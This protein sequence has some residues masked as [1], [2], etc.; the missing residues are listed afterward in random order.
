MQDYY[1]L[2]Q[3]HPKADQDSIHAAYLRLRE[4]YAAERMEGAAE[5]L[6]ALARKRRDEIERAY[7]TLNDPVRRAA[8]DAES[9][10][11]AGAKDQP[12][13]A[14]DVAEALDYRPLP[15]AKRKS[16]PANFNPQP[17]LSAA[18]AAPRSGRKSR[19]GRPKWV[20]PGTLGGSIAAIIMIVTLVVTNVSNI[21][22]AAPS[23]SGTAPTVQ[24]TPS[25]AEIINQFEGEIVA[26]R[27]V[28]QQIPNNANAWI[29][30]GNA[31]YDSVQIVH[32]RLPDSAIYTERLPRWIEASDAYSKALALS[33]NNPTVRADLA[34]SYCYYGTST[35]EA[36]FVDRGIT[37][38]R[39][40]IV[41]GPQDPRAMLNL[42]ICLIADDPPQTAEAVSTWKQLVGMTTLDTGMRNA[43]QRLL[44]TYGK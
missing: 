9:R 22:K 37:E 44:D 14:T 38:A 3:V 36:S 31:I 35:K 5:E 29:N 26:A 40:A 23:S 20:V 13:A 27:Q 21:P 18:S 34:A 24:P 15:P 41:D 30:L 6:V 32:E 12:A 43:V 33:P 39:R 16:R 42:G 8:Y 7:A 17:T 11:S 25:E 10:T 19:K 2:L 1:E 28:T 4:R